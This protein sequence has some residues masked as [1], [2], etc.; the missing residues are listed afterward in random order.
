MERGGGSDGTRESSEESVGCRDEVEE[1]G[2][3]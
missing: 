3:G 1:Q 2:E